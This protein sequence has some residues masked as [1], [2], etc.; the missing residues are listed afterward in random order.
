MRELMKTSNPAFKTQA[1]RNPATLAGER[2]SVNGTLGKSFILLV[3]VL[4]TAAWCWLRFYTVIGVQGPAAAAS[5][6]APFLIGGAIGGL[7]LA[8]VTAFKP[9]W[10]FI[11]APL[12]ALAEGLVVGGASALFEL[13][14][15]G[16]VVQ[17]VALTLAVA[18]GMLILYRTGV[19]KVTDRFRRMIFA[20]TFGIVIF[21]GLTWL[22]SLFGVD[23]T[24]VYGHT[25][26]SIGIS[27]F[28]V[29]IAAFNL[30]LDFDLIARQS[31]LG[32]PRYMEWYGAFALMVTLIWLYLEILRLL[33]NVRR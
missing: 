14:Y 20:A 19:I 13:R 5:A 28:I 6:I 3:L 2:M 18:F 17:A 24:L 21:Y 30:V 16:I 4:V 26:L 22:V 32:A 15:P 33:G 9:T 23:T 8:L 1:F 27:L 7:V 25:P 29:A 11:S 12:Y 31:Q 10:A